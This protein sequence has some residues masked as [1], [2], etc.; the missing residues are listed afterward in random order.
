M[1]VCT[2]P[3][4]EASTWEGVSFPCGWPVAGFDPITGRH[5]CRHHLAIQSDLSHR[6]FIPGTRV[7]APGRNTSH[8]FA[9]WTHSML[10]AEMLCGLRLR[11][12][13]EYADSDAT[14]LRCL[15]RLNQP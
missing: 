14:C 8:I 10:F 13:F 9:R 5:L 1:A 12:P 3:R 2:W 4:E 15:R 11:R 6:Q 7:R